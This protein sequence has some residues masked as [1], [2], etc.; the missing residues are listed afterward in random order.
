MSYAMTPT[1]SVD[2]PQF[3][4]RL[5]A[6][7]VVQ[8]AGPGCDGAWVSFDPLTRSR[9]RLGP[10]VL[11]VAVARTVLAPAVRVALTVT[12]DQVSQLPVGGK[13]DE[14]TTVPLTL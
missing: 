9:S 14:V 7:M 6:V 12:V 5:F 2:A 13:F 4:V 3:R 1:L 11:P 10:P 8:F